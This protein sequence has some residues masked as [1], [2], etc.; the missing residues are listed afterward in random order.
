[1]ATRPPAAQTAFGPMVI[2]AA[3]RYVPAPRRVIDDELAIRFLPAA[4]RAVIGACRWRPARDWLAGATDKRAPGIWGGVLCR[5]R[6]ADDA[7]RESLHDGIGQL[8]VLGAGLDTRAYRLAAPAGVP[9]FEVD[10]PTNIDYKRRRVTAL[11]GR[12]PEHVTLVPID[13][14]RE[15]LAAALAAAGLRDNRPAMFVWEAVTQYLTEAAVHATLAAVSTAAPGSRLIFTYVRK[16]FLDGANPY[17][18]ERLRRDFVVRRRV[19]HFGIDPS[20]VAGLLREHGW[21]EREQVGPAEYHARYLEPAG[22][23]LPV[24]EIERFVL[25]VKP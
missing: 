3:E 16:D 6:Y 12:V 22:R 23:E 19:W 11:Y 10:L 2:A 18:A 24:S 9:S 17:G 20:A 7:V 1:M 4:A 8:V 25:A 21:D 5:K 14:G 13:L 15:D